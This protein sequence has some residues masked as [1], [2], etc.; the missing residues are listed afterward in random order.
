MTNNNNNKN[1]YW[2][3]PAATFAAGLAVAGAIFYNAQKNDG[4]TTPT[5]EAPRTEMTNTM[6]SNVNNMYTDKSS[7]V[8]NTGNFIVGDVYDSDVVK[9]LPQSKTVEMKTDSLELVVKDLVGKN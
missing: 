4:A 6:N 3:R 5:N 9:S 8:I 1:L 2:L 7:N